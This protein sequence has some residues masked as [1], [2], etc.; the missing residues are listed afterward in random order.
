[1]ELRKQN[2][3][4]SKE[5]LEEFSPIRLM[6]VE[7]SKPLPGLKNITGL[8]VKDPVRLMV[9]LRLHRK[10]LGLI[11]IE[12]PPQG[13][14]SRAFA[15]RIWQSLAG[16]INHHLVEDGL[17][18]VNGLNENGIPSIEMPECI[19]LRHEYLETAPFVNVI[20]ATRDR[21][22][23]LQDALDSILISN[24]PNFE[25]IVVDNAPST[26]ATARLIK[27]TY[28][29]TG[30]VRYVRE[31]W[32]GLSVAHNR[33]ILEANAP[34]IAITDDDVL[35]DQDWLTELMRGFSAYDHVGCVTGLIFPQELQSR[36]QLWFEQ[37]GGFNKGFKQRVF[38]LRNHRPDDPL[39]PYTAGKFGTGANM[40]FR[41]SV[42]L[43]M[44]GFDPA[45]GIGTLTF[46]GDDLS[47]FF[48]VIQH[49]YQLVY[50]PDAIVHHRHR[51]DYA[52]LRR[53]IY[54]YGVGL[55]AFLMKT[56][57]DRPT[58]LFDLLT[59]IPY[60]LFFTL[61]DRSPK[62][63]KKRSDY[64]DE[65]TRLERKGM[66]YGP[67][68]YLRSRWKVRQLRK[69]M[70]IK[71]LSRRELVAIRVTSNQGELRS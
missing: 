7:I 16:E 57:V 54:G 39:Y 69:D 66:I 14:S 29:H 44:G 45:T 47:A 65:L 58:R 38:D 48:D 10:P 2:S 49:G 59:R 23:R 1:M 28:A 19:R 52:G 22:K 3:L 8:A 51:S 15:D 5:N 6:D 20:I 31:D 21:T 40:A 62:N 18:V 68:A 61:S 64:P 46:G 27:E 35:V 36:S 37:Y 9:F 12:L 56:L 13:L 43:E 26:D 30:R 50:Q 32:P 41:T 42:L 11:E 4:I 53:Q 67:I 70:E 25:I 24:Y 17:N 63:S 60:G 33:G 34:Y 71:R 55:T